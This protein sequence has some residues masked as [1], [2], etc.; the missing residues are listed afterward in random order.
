MLA[1]LPIFIQIQEEANRA[2][3]MAVTSLEDTVRSLEQKC[4]EAEKNNIN[5]KKEMDELK[6]MER[7]SNRRKEEVCHR[8]T[9]TTLETFNKEIPAV[10]EV[11]GK[12]LTECYW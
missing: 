4:I 6:Q 10:V 9:Q 5:L 12:T 7:D 8:S 11:K 2:H 1:L 3:E